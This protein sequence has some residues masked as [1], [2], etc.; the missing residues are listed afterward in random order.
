VVSM[1]RSR[2]LFR[3]DKGVLCQ[4][5]SPG[6]E[7]A[8]SPKFVGASY[9]AA[10]V[11]LRWRKHW[12]VNG[13]SKRPPCAELTMLPDASRQTDTLL[14]LRQLDP[15]TRP[16]D[17]ECDD[18]G[19]TIC[20]DED[21]ADVPP[22][23]Q[24]DPIF[25]PEPETVEEA[26]VLSGAAST[27][28]LGWDKL[29]PREAEKSRSGFPARRRPGK[30][31]LHRGMSKPLM[32]TLFV[33]SFF[34]GLQFF[35]ANSTN[36]PAT[37]QESSE[38]KKMTQVSTDKPEVTEPPITEAKTDKALNN[39]AAA[40]PVAAK[41]PPRSSNAQ[42][43]PKGSLYARIRQVVQENK[44]EETDRL[45]MGDVAYL[46]VP[47]DG[48]IMVGMEVSYVPFFT[49][50]VIK[51]VRPIY[52]KSNGLRY[53]GPICGNPTGVSERVV[54]K[55][56]YAI[57]GASIWSGMGIDGMQLTFM[58]IGPAGLN[59]S[60]SYLSKWLGGHGGA[61][62]KTY[63]NDGRPVIGIS[64]MV[65]NWS[66]GPAFCMGFVTTK[67]GALAEADGLLSGLV[68]SNNATPRDDLRNPL[69]QPADPK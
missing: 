51:S 23:A 19:L 20:D 49:H 30:A 16:A 53:D 26:P 52:Q 37:R 44:T 4:R 57:G 59:P 3:I 15:D 11:P 43:K 7:L 8:Q 27:S 67:A 38:A 28:P 39:K 46:N 12:Q 9:A 35:W 47:Q 41:A 21:K 56:G 50:N 31:D 2:K 58:E 48:S 62:A 42:P 29:V 55:A 64:G 60:K 66:F 22:R 17:T 25:V 6:H 40:A 1:G 45:G 36:P 14:R 68:P 32:W 34:T 24:P 33:A 69:G 65:S 18:W 61:N 63:L 13:F 5:R 10:D 54:A